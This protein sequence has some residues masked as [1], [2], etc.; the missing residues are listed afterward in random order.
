MI[1]KN[2]GAVM[3]TVKPLLSGPSWDPKL[4]LV[5]RNV[6][7]TE[8]SVIIKITSVLFGENAGLI[9]IQFRRIFSMYR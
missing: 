1:P 6:C 3:Y 5:L 2:S 9:R 7:L 4:S 8:I